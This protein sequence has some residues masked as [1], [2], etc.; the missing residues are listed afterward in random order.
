MIYMMLPL[1][2]TDKAERGLM[3]LF[4][5]LVF[6][7]PLLKNFLPTPLA[8]A[9]IYQMKINSGGLENRPRIPQLSKSGAGK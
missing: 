6:V 7:A 2:D 5:G 1:H 8:L 3:V 9:K 4:F